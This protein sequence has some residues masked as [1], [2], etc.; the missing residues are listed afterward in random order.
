MTVKHYKISADNILPT[1][2]NTSNVAAVL[3]TS[4]GTHRLKSYKSLSLNAF[5]CTCWLPSSYPNSNLLS[6][7][8]N[9]IEPSLTCLRRIKQLNGCCLLCSFLHK[10]KIVRQETWSVYCPGM[11][12]AASW[13]PGRWP[14]FLHWKRGFHGHI[15]GGQQKAKTI[16]KYL[17]S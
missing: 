4:S 17:P 1:K 13:T 9:G 11:A 16:Y 8:K 10:E 6:D 12:R 3:T 7:E 5:T 14:H 2:K 15:V